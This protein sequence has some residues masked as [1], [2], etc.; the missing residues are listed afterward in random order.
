MTRPIALSAGNSV[1]NQTVAGA[2]SSATK[3]TTTALVIFVG[4]AA[5]VVIHVFVL[6]A[7]PMRR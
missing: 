1:S 6:V 4:M 3:V 2:L 7:S 5:L